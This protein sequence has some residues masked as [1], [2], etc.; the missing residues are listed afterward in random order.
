MSNQHTPASAP[1]HAELIAGASNSFATPTH[2]TVHNDESACS[3]AP[4]NVKKARRGAFTTD[5]ER[6]LMEAKQ[7]LNAALRKLERV[8]KQNAEMKTRLSAFKRPMKI[9]K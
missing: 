6:E 3:N 9:P 1:Q 5:T 2:T 4:V 8:E 7:Q